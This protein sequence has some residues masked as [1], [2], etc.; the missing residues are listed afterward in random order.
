MSKQSCIDERFPSSVH[1]PAGLVETVLDAHHQ[2][3]HPALRFPEIDCAG[4]WQRLRQ[5]EELTII[6]VRP[7]QAFRLCRIPTA[8]DWASVWDTDAVPTFRGPVVVYDTGPDRLEAV[9]VAAALK[10]ADVNAFVMRGGL[11][12]WRGAGY[13]VEGEADA[14]RIYVAI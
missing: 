12:A 7:T 2:G 5:G 11:T 13:P 10:A 6:D 3:S 8:I 14:P 9:C 1:S 4:A